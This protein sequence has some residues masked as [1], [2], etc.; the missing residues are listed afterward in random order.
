MEELDDVNF[1]KV[2]GVLKAN[3]YG[4]FNARVIKSDAVVCKIS[5][6]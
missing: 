3:V 1:H 2:P 4:T 6:I 5:R